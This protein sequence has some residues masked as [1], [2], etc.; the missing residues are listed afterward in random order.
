MRRYQVQC[1]D[2]ATGA[3]TPVLVDATSEDAARG[4]AIDE[5]HLVGRVLDTGPANVAYS[6]SPPTR[7]PAPS[8]DADEQRRQEMIEAARQWQQQRASTG[9]SVSSF[10]AGVGGSGGGGSGGELAEISRALKAIAESRLVAKP[11]RTLLVCV[12]G[13]LFIGSTIT[14]VLTTMVQLAMTGSALN[15]TIAT[16]AAP[17][18]TPSTPG[19]G[20]PQTGTNIDPQMLAMVQQM[21]AQQNAG[22]AGPLPGTPGTGVSPAQ[23]KSIT[24]Q[25]DAIKKLYEDTANNPM[26]DK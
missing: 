5:G 4:W 9:T 3:E 12:V 2:R 21:M 19:T 1:V 7:T 14:T 16:V 26:G 13:G 18:S 15:R 24:D 20:T 10:G 6:N 22:G 11:R 23:L 25:L 17:A 8:S